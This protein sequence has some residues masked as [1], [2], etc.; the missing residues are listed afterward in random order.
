MP[1]LKVDPLVWSKVNSCKVL[2]SE[3]WKVLVGMNDGAGGIGMAQNDAGGRTL[4]VF[5]HYYMLCVHT[6]LGK[7]F[8]EEP[9]WF[10]WRSLEIMGE[11][12]LAIREKIV[13]QSRVDS[14]V[15][16]EEFNFREIRDSCGAIWLK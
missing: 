6:I 8:K 2:H 13:S 12:L 3:F 10:G 1:H 9:G 7:V 16:S 4:T 5:A 15:L 11:T 14:K